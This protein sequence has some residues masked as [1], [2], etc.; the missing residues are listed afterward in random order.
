MLNENVNAS[1]NQVDLLLDLSQM[2]SEPSY[3][4]CPGSKRA[5]RKSRLVTLKLT[6]EDRQMLMLIVQVMGNQLAVAFLLWD[7]GLGNLEANAS[8]HSWTNF[9][10]AH[11]TLSCWMSPQL[12]LLYVICM[13]GCTWSGDYV[14]EGGTSTIHMD[15][16]PKVFLAQSIRMVLL[17]CILSHLILMLSITRVC[18]AQRL[19]HPCDVKM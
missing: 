18:Q 8:N 15:R 16:G 4:C 19:G 12:S 6:K 9:A 3:K 1:Q 10:S 5:T 11:D 2:V 7:S 14:Q 13:K 17:A